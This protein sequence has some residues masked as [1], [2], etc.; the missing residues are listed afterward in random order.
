MKLTMKRKHIILGCGVLFML[1]IIGIGGKLYMDYEKKQEELR[2]NLVESKKEITEMLEWNYKDIKSVT[3]G[4]DG[5]LS[6]LNIDPSLSITPVGIV[7]IN[8]WVNGDKKLSFDGEL[9]T[10]LS[11]ISGGVGS[12]GG[13]LGLMAKDPNNVLLSKTIIENKTGEVS[14]KELQVIIDKTQNSTNYYLDLKDIE[15]L[16]QQGFTKD[17]TFAQIKQYFEEKKK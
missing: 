1:V 13:K 5:N 2:A 11:K 9:N 15:Y 3:F 8:G 4:Y 10:E 6:K 17:I 16:K 12:Y 14:D 7:T